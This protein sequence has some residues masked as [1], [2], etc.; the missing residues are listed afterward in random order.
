[1]SLNK[2]CYVGQETLA[3]LSTY[4]GVKQQLR[5]WSWTPQPGELPGEPP[6]AL[7]PGTTLYFA[8][9]TGNSTSRAGVISSSLE[10]EDGSWIGLALVR[11]QALQQPLLQAG[12]GPRPATL[13][14]S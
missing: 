3:K 5:R 7:T 4:D 10:L 1:M 14:L 9:A 2:G 11:K 13:L 8:D 6:A 12:D